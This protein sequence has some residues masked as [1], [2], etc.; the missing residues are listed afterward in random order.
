MQERRVHLDVG[1]CFAAFHYIRI[2]YPWVEGYH[3]S[4]VLST[5][6]DRRAFQRCVPLHGPAL[7]CTFAVDGAPHECGMTSFHA[8]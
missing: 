7:V 1:H 2:F 6:V 4:A 8:A 3:Y 5:R